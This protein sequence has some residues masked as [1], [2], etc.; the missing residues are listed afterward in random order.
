[1]NNEFF[2]MLCFLILILTTI[3]C[4][5]RIKFLERMR[6]KRI[7]SY[8]KNWSQIEMNEYNLTNKF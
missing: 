3:N 2:Q 7:R 6:D 1:M 4:L 5:M 8:Q